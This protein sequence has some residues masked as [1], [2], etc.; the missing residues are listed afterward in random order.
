MEINLG[1]GDI[2]MEWILV[3]EDPE[4]EWYFN[5]EKN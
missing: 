1:V 4:I 5:P 3:D 2:Q